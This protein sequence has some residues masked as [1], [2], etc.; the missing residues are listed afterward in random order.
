MDSTN[1]RANSWKVGFSCISLCS[2]LQEDTLESSNIIE[3]RSKRVTSRGLLQRKMFLR[4]PN[5]ETVFHYL[6]RLLIPPFQNPDD[7]QKRILTKANSVW[8][9]LYSSII[10]GEFILKIKSSMYLI[11]RGLLNWLLNISLLFSIQH[12]RSWQEPLTAVWWYDVGCKFE[13]MGLVLFLD[14][15]VI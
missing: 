7:V 3:A 1:T 12:L 5:F 9:S 10:S 13:V 11:T 14:S 8:W 4:A 6:F 2:Y 15:T